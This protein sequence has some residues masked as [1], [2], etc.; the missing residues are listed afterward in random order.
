MLKM[1]AFRAYK[2]KHSFLNLLCLHTVDSGI[3]HRWNEQVH[4]CNEGGHKRWEMFSKS[5]NKRQADQGNIE[6]GHSS[7]VRNAGAEGLPPLPG[8]A[9]LRTQR[10]I[11]T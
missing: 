8:D 2:F 7:D 1:S 6:C 4:I 10:M 11:R 3:H 9:L 5:V